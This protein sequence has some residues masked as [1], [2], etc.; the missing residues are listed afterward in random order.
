MKAFLFI[1]KTLLG[2]DIITD[3]NG[4]FVQ[5]LVGY[6][7]SYIPDLALSRKSSFADFK[8]WSTNKARTKSDSS[9]KLS[10][11]GLLKELLKS[12]CSNN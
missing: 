2:T 3:P 5:D 12:V 6:R 11:F 9:K 7:E 8:H 1:H 4:I 10:Q